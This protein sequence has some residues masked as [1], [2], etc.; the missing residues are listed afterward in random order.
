MNEYIKYIILGIIQ[1][2]TEIL[3]I[4]SSGH[5]IIFQEIFNIKNILPDDQSQLS[6]LPNIEMPNI[7]G[8]TVAEA[9]AKLKALGLSINIDGLG[10]RIIAQLPLHGAKI[11][12]GEEVLLFA[13]D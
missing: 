9:C 5:L 1:G 11:Y 10:G 6:N 4:S 7:T 3:P 12:E 8:Q 13:S 2:L